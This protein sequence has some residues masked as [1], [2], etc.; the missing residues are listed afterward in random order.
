MAGDT[1]I[2][3]P[4]CFVVRFV[5]VADTAFQLVHRRCRQEFCVAI[6]VGD[7]IPIIRGRRWI[8]RERSGINCGGRLMIVLDFIGLERCWF[9][10]G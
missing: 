8:G 5:D 9:G 1:I 7:W 2:T 4:S 10:T 3:Y 6:T